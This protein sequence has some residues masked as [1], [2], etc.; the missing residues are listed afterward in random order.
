MHL[1]AIAH[2]RKRRIAALMAIAGLRRVR[3]GGI[4]EL[5]APALT[6]RRHRGCAEGSRGVLEGAQLE[7]AGRS[8]RRLQGEGQVDLVRLAEPQHPVRAVHGAG[9]QAGRQARR[10]QGRRLRRQVLGRR[11]GPRH[12]PGRAVE[13]LG[14]HARRRRAV[15]RRAR[16]RRREEGGHPRDHG[17]HPGSGPDAQGL[18]AGRR[19]HGDPLLLVAGPGRGRL[20]HGRLEGQGQDPLHEHER[21]AR[22]SRARRSRPS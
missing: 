15:A 9:H 14:D 21:P 1:K 22:T 16:A 18:P 19:R 8:V 13:G 10:R 7:A 3:R 11:R 20:H 17:Q 2:G 6:R 4:G 5:D 12:P